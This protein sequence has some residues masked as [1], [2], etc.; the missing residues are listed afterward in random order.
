MAPGP[1]QGK[2]GVNT[3]FLCPAQVPYPHG[4]YEKLVEIH[5]VDILGWK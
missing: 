4:C 5:P 1:F 3:T 2:R